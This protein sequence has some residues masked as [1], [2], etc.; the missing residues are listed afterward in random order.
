MILKVQNQ[1]FYTS[2]S[3]ISSSRPIFIGCLNIYSW[4]A[5]FM[6]GVSKLMLWVSELILWVSAFPDDGGGDGIPTTLQIW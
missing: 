3:I 4:V 5:E 1:L 2:K 6:L